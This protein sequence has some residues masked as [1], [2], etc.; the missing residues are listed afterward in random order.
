MTTKGV[1]LSATAC[2]VLLLTGC[3]GSHDSSESKGAP[4]TPRDE[5]V[6]TE[7]EFPAGTRKMDVPQEK[8][9][10]SLSDMDAIMAGATVTPD[11]CRAPQVDLAAAA[12]HV[13]ASSSF[14]LATSEDMTSYVDYVANEVMDL[15]ALADNHAKCPEVTVTSTANGD[16]I[17]TTTKL[18]KLTVPS[19]I[20]GT[21][22]IAYRSTATSQLGDDK[23]ITQTTYEG[24]ATLRG[25]T[26][27]VRA[28][29]F[30]DSPDQS[31]FDTF[32]TAAVQKVQNAK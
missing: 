17:V 12:K 23:P 27:G 24:Y 9:Q 22:A 8:L 6:L 7:S 2:A 11:Q 14:A 30:A 25:M 26:V 13:L 31:A 32:F 10:S 5:L 16:K 1:L 15:T 21:D 20:S 4:S 19:A 18:E 3:G 29:A 28:S